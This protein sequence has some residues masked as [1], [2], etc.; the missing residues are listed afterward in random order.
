M[1]KNITYITRAEMYE[2]IYKSEKASCMNDGLT[3]DKASRFANIF[4]VKNTEKYWL[5]VTVYR[6]KKELA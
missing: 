1:A 5:E 3:E 2:A 4:A 6:L